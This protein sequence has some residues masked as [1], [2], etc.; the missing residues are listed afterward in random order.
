MKV[1]LIH[2]E[3]FMYLFYKNNG[4]EILAVKIDSSMFFLQY[5]FSVVKVKYYGHSGSLQDLHSGSLNERWQ[6]IG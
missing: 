6:M 1:K 2:F 4:R 3:I 5:N